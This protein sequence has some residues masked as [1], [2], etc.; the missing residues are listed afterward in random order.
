MSQ[1]IIAIG[2]VETPVDL[3]VNFGNAQDNFTEIY[4]KNSEQDEAITL[5]QTILAEGAFV[6][7]D[8]NALDYAQP[9]LGTV[10]VAGNYLIEE[11]VTGVTSKLIPGT[12][13]IFYT[14]DAGGG[15]K[16][17]SIG[18]FG[19]YLKSNGTNGAPSWESPM[20]SENASTLSAA[21]ANDFTAGSVGYL[22][23]DGTVML[24]D[25][26]TEATSK[27]M[28]LMATATIAGEASGVFSRGGLV[29][30]TGHGF[31]IG[32][33]LF[34][35]ET[36]GAITNTAPGS[37]TFVRVIGYALDVNTIDFRPDGAWVAV[38]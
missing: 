33:P 27:A 30:V 20:T 11:T 24:A 21:A 4:I 28:L 31:A 2:T 26:N 14:D 9:S 25:A 16:E 34:L 37:G 32:L 3:D 38:T 23:T 29:T 6:N 10:G 8:K 35:S 7:G 19:T 36:A 22:H 1:K 18:T 15:L 5:K 12:W 17:L 13:K